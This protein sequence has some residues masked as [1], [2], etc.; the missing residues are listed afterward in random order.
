MKIKQIL[1]IFA[2]GCSMVALAQYPSEYNVVWNTLST[3]SHESMPCGG[4][5]V[6]TN[7]WVE[8]GDILF[9]FS[10]SGT[11]D[12]HNGFLKGGRIRVHLTPNPFLSSPFRQ[13]LKLHEGCVEISGGEGKNQ[14]KVMLW[15]DV[16]HPVVHVEIESQQKIDVEASLESW[17]FEDFVLRKDES[18]ANSYKFAPPVGL[19]ITKDVI[20]FE[21]NAICFYHRN[22]ENTVFDVAVERQGMTG[23]KNKMM[24]PLSNLTFGGMLTGKSFVIKG[25]YEGEYTD[26][27]F[28]GWTLKSS[29]TSKK[30]E[31]RLYLH[32]D[33]AKM[34]D[35]WKAGLQK[36]MVDE[37]KTRDK[38]K[39]DTRE[40]WQRFWQ[41]SFIRI[42]SE[43]QN[44][45][46][47]KVGRNYQLFRYML[48]CN[49]YGSEPTKFNGGLFTFDPVHV[50]SAR[51]FTPD[52]RLWGG[53]TMTAQNQRLVYFPMLKSGDFDM[54]HSQ[55]NFYER[56]LQNAELR[57]MVYWGHDG[58]CFTEQIEQFG[59]PNL[60][61]YAWQ[62]HR[63]EMDQGV[64]SNPWLEYT[65]DTAME[66][67]L[68]M[69]DAYDYNKEPIRPHLPFIESTIRFFDEHYRYLASKR[70]TTELD[71]D[72]HWVLYPGSAA[73]TYKMAT[74][75]T[76][77]IAALETI[78]HRLLALPE[79]ETT[80]KERVR[81][82]G[83]LKRVPSLNYCEIDGKRIL[84]PAKMWE[85]V[86]NE[87]TPQLYPVFPWRMYG[88]GRPGL[89]V[90]VDTYL[91]DPKAL[92]YRGYRSWKQ[93]NIWAACL[94]L[95]E[96]A[97]SLTLQKMT[98][99]PYRFPVFWGP[100][101]DWTPDHNWGGSGM[102][103]VQEMLLQT[104]GDSIL[105]FPAW[106]EDWNVHF[107][108]HA[109]KGTVVEV[110]YRDGKVIDC[111]VTPATRLKDVVYCN[112]LSNGNN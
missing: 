54:M 48:A 2:L 76:S 33:Q 24:N 71:G 8:N 75:A 64:E 40:W 3:G 98:D 47:W 102:I 26:T 45:E 39:V 101:F 37:Q 91:H 43:R 55:F 23:V 9:Y 78:L 73:E 12:E 86:N 88:V 28:K 25:T 14:S 107:R 83:W 13:E 99:G 4:G 29:H 69:L 17:R 56:M 66:F 79:S 87:E 93:D 103:G 108:L 16:F 7:V 84:S 61:E 77:T 27:K 58:A 50:D 95:T 31:V 41:R 96:E 46:S 11:F 49:A 1:L 60:S 110:E 72:G 63:P 111:Q 104:V 81:W 53:G 100:G 109:P 68:M 36:L 74:N 19:K 5:S 92:K 62:P 42:D 10:H 52:F 67:G 35:D 105:L 85:R 51:A 34:L 30:H 80:E 90:A 38:N 44:S 57:S 32:N 112:K 89:K 20:T 82:G 59:L 70:G 106:P 21:D 22:P 18:H 65:W 97:R 15:A 94:G 6:G